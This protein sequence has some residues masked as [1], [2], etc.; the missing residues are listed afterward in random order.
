MQPLGHQVAKRFACQASIARAARIEDAQRADVTVRVAVLH[1]ENCASRLVNWRHFRPRLFIAQTPP[2]G[3]VRRRRRPPKV[4]RVGR[5]KGRRGLFF[6]AGPTTG[7]REDLS[8]R[9]RQS[10]VGSPD[11]ARKRKANARQGG[12]APPWRRRSSCSNRSCFPRR[13]HRGAVRR[14]ELIGSLEDSGAPPLVLL[15]AGPGWGKTT[16]L[17]QWASRSQRPFAWVSVDEKDNDPI[18]LLTYVAV[19]LDR[20]SRLDPSVFDAL[21]VGWRVGRGDGRAAFGSGSGGDE[22]AGRPGPGRPPLAR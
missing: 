19:A 11:S 10:G 1:R 20:V 21:G 2:P 18:V 12:A 3:R 14:G 7:E 15:S 6:H 22:R 8:N 16:L 4:R 9:L 5:R 13:V 17:A